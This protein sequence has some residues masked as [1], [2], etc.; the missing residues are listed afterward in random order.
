MQWQLKGEEKKP[1]VHELKTKT[2]H[3]HTKDG[4]SKQ[5]STE[6]KRGLEEIHQWVQ[7]MIRTRKETP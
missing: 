6:E 4:G 2:T 3:Y 5:G 7:V 1:K